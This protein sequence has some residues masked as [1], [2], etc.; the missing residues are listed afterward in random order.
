M[1]EYYSEAEQYARRKSSSR[2]LYDAVTPAEGHCKRL[3]DCF[4]E[5]VVCNFQT[6]GR[7]EKIAE[8]ACDILG[9][10]PEV[11]FEL[12]DQLPDHSPDYSIDIASRTPVPRV[13]GWR[14]RLIS[15]VLRFNQRYSRSSY[16]SSEHDRY[17]A[18]EIHRHNCKSHQ[19]II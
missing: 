11:P 15:C 5:N 16:R 10:L 9:R 18:D 7:H 12:P 4:A 3:D 14:E 2:Q 1:H 6:H 13:V 19:H 17:N 8:D